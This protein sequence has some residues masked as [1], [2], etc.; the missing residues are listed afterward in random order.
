[1]PRALEHYGNQNIY[2][3]IIIMHNNGQEIY[4]YMYIFIYILTGKLIETVSQIKCQINHWWMTLQL[5]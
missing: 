3:Y 5:N 2:I 4:I 1:M